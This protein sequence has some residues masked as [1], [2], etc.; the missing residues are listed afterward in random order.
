MQGMV[1]QLIVEDGVCTGV[2]TQTGAVYKAKTVVITTG[3]S[4]AGKLF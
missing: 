4:Y 1:E 3:H 2:V